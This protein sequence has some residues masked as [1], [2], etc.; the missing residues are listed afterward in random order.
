MSGKS[1]EAPAEP[2]GFATISSRSLNLSDPA[3]STP[4]LAQTRSA[5]GSTRSCPPD[6]LAPARPALLVVLPHEHDRSSVPCDRHERL[7]RSLAPD[8][9]RPASAFLF[10]P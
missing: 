5:P 1:S 9:G 6:L 2:L 3:E 8:L 10:H 4:R 7:A